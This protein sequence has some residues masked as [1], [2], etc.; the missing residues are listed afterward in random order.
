MK[1]ITVLDTTLR[2][3]E[4]APGF[5]MKREQKVEIALQLERMKVDIIEAGFPISSQEDFASVRE[6]AETI[7][8]CSVAGFCRATAGDISCAYEAV[9]HSQ[10]PRIN[11]FLATSDIHI[12]H[13]LRTTREE[14]LRAAVEA[15]RFARKHCEDVEFIA[16]DATRSDREFLLEFFKCV[17][18]AGASTLV[19]ADTVGFATPQEIADITAQI[20][21]ASCRKRV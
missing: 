2:D 8:D 1:N 20:G 11:I 7:K 15:V 10:R 14:I 17:A 18:G 12:E 6:I 16:E 3:G 19:I 9:K 13:K 21:R 5:S 4:Q